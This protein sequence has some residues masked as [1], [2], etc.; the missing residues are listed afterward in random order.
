[1][2]EQIL[3]NTTFAPYFLQ[4][5]F[6]IVMLG[7]IKWF[8]SLG[9]MTSV[10]S[11]FLC[12]FPPFLSPSLKDPLFSS[13]KVSGTFLPPFSFLDKYLNSARPTLRGWA[14]FPLCPSLMGWVLFFFGA[15][16]HCSHRRSE[17]FCLDVGFGPDVHSWN[18]SGVCPASTPGPALL[19]LGVSLPGAE[20]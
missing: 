5:E 10:Q 6:F 1:M 8:Y 7:E 12:W 3:I 15:L 19:G 11:Y 9:G 18:G 14:T 16:R 4:Q 2:W 17:W 20:I 13:A